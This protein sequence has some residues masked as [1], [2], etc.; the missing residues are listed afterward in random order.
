MTELSHEILESFQV[1]KTRR[2]KSAF[3]QLLRTHFPALR[4]EEGGFPRSRNLILGDPA[5]AKVIFSAHYDTCAVLPFPNLIFPKNVV[6]SLLYGVLICIPF[7]LVLA[8][9]YAALNALFPGNALNMLFADALFLLVLFV[10]L[11]AGPPN[12]HTANDNTSG[13]ITLCELI[14]TLSDA[15]RADVAF[16]FF[17]NEENGLLG[18]A[19][20]RKR[21]RDTLKDTLLINFDCVSDGDTLLF[22]HSKDAA[23]RYAPALETAFRSQGGKTACHLSATRTYYPSDQAGFPVGVAV[24]AAKTHRL[25][26]LYLNRIHTPRDTVFDRRN[27]EYLCSCTK[28]FLQQLR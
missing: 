13:V 7:L 14:A 1:R 28:N 3:I 8:A 25:F 20:F 15:E 21:H 16:V 2:Q 9:A 12:R 18:S 23:A 11:F 4:L 5:T 27:I 22:I 26:G 19:F 17:D 10:V 24:A 6:L